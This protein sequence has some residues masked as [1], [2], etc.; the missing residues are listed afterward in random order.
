MVGI[1]VKENR[2]VFIDNLKLLMM[3]LVVIQHLALT[4]SGIGDW[5]YME[6]EQT[7]F[8]QAWFF[9]YFVSFTQGYFMGLFF[10]ISGYFIP[11]S[12]DRKGFKKFV[13]DRLIRLGIPVLIYTIIIHPVTTIMVW[14]P[15]A[16]DNN[17][18]VFYTEYIFHFK[19]LLNSGPL[20]FAFALL[21][22]STIYAIIRKLN[23]LKPA[24]AASG[25]PTLPKIVLLI[26]AIGV[27]T[28]LVRIVH[29]VD[30]LTLNMRLAHFPLYIILLITGMVCRRSEWFEKINYSVGKRWFISANT[31]GPI[32]WTITMCL[33]MFLS[34]STFDNYSAFS[35]GITWESAVYSIWESFI[36]I[37]MSIGL[38]SIF[39]EKLNR[40]NNL[41]QKMTDNSFAVYVFHTPV[42]TGMA[43]LFEDIP[44]YPIVKFAILSII[45]IPICFLLTYFT[46]R[47]IPF[48]KKLFE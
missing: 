2:L 4:Y 41:I 27:I 24:K 40:R 6:Y 30:K 15:L 17:P 23:L 28:F 20:W 10:L 32:Y 34:R 1:A 25:L 35:G 46:V 13:K 33:S 3:I 19:F 39:K 18:L 7:G 44:F 31:I 29:P 22:F 38:I 16:Y 26:L 9:F 11:V 43:L 36:S 12:Y 14:G 8:K 47:K 42:I 5:Y 48:L 45:S 21:I 37:S